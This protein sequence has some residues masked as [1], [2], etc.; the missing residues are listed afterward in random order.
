MAEKIAGKYNCYCT[1]SNAEYEFTGNNRGA[2]YSPTGDTEQRLFLKC[3]ENPLLF[4]PR[5]YDT[6]FIYNNKVTIKR[7][8]IISRGANGLRNSS[9]TAAA[10]EI[11]IKSF[12]GGLL[13]PYRGLY[14]PNWNEWTDINLDFDCW[15]DPIDLSRKNEFLSFYLDNEKSVFYVDDYNIQASYIGQKFYPELELEIET[16]GMYTTNSTHTVKRIF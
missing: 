9:E 1:I 2:Y 5:Q 16:A 3:T 10:I 11:C 13:T 4:F 8:R 15:D 6:G 14:F 7:A 12:G